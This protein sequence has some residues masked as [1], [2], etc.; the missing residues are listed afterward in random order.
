MENTNRI[1][2]KKL[3]TNVHI[4]L[5]LLLIALMLANINIEV[6]KHY[7]AFDENPL[8]FGAEKYEIRQCS[9]FT[10][11]DASF[12]FNQTSIW[13]EKKFSSPHIPLNLSLMEGLVNATE[14][15]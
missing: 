3:I 4:F 2:E 9:C 10:T 6:R 12:L 15:N 7:E 5:I 8:L 14:D 11:R 1:K 13:Q